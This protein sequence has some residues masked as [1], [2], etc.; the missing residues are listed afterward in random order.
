MGRVK[1]ALR[2][3][4]LESDTPQQALE[5]TDRKVQ[6]FEIDTMITVVCAVSS[7]PYDRFDIS[8][9]SHLAPVRAGDPAIV[10]QTVM[11]HLVGNRP[12]IDDIAVLALRR[13]ASRT[14][15]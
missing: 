6:H 7:P 3:Y 9:A 11:H 14:A 5:R 13:T 4:A 1:S 12:R 15:I 10:C 2:A 8:S